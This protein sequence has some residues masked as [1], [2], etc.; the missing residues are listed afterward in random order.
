[1]STLKTNILAVA[2]TW[3]EPEIANII[4]LKDYKF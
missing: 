3:L 4:S 1:M 2:E